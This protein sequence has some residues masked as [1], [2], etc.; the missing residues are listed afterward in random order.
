M[1]KLGWITLPGFYA[2]MD[3]VS[4]QRGEPK[5]T[6][7]DVAALL[8]RLN[9]EDIAG[10]VMDLRRNGGGSLEEAINLTGL[11][12]KKGPVVQSKDYNKHIDVSATRTRAS[13]TPGR[14][15]C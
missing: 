5:S 13:P 14:W 10:L 2:D 1:D 6:T 15:S 11:F 12:I 4:R 3:R 8:G 9:K 7:R